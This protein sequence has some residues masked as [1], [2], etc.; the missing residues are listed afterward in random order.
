M[1][2]TLMEDE[3]ILLLSVM[4]LLVNRGPLSAATS[5][6]TKWLVSCF[7]SLFPNAC[8]TFP[9]A[10]L[11]APRVNR[12][13]IACYV[14]PRSSA[15]CI[16]ALGERSHPVSQAGHLLKDSGSFCLPTRTLQILC[17]P[18]NCSL[19]LNHYLC[20]RPLSL[21]APHPHPGPLR[22]PHL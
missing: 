6:S 5:L 12:P 3:Q 1:L 17:P 16:C 2:V 18:L 10:C 22:T 19:L 9:L 20:S 4:Q 14:L 11:H 8:W 15:S 7:T 13:M 21:A